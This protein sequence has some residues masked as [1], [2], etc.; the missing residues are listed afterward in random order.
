[1]EQI[2][3]AS[4]G[5]QLPGAENLWREFTSVALALTT[6]DPAL[7][8]RVSES[9]ADL[10]FMVEAVGDDIGADAVDGIQQLLDHQEE[11]LAFESLCTAIARSNARISRP[12]FERLQAV[13][14]TLKIP[15]HVWGQVRGSV[16]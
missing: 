9:A 12:S 2:R 4:V 14:R 5:Y 15:A 1:M 16:P 11:I 6:R 8:R 13:G 10:R 7:F 3:Q